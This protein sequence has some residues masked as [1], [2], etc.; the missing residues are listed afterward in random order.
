VTKFLIWAFVA[1]LTLM[2]ARL[3]AQANGPKNVGLL[4]SWLNGDFSE[5]IKATE[6]QKTKIRQ[7][8]RQVRPKLVEARQGGRR[9]ED[10]FELALS[11]DNPDE[12]RIGTAIQNV[13]KA[14]S[15]MTQLLLQVTAD[16]R[17]VLTGEQW[18]AFQLLQRNRKVRLFD[19]P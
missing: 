7:I 13:A 4:Q 16:I 9:A 12:G 1:T 10:E 2:P 3:H 14:R 11:S 18:R 8:L 19:L 17:A 6:E 15:T 5:E